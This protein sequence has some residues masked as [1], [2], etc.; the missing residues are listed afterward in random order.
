MLSG[1]AEQCVRLGLLAALQ[2]ASSICIR[3]GLSTIHYSLVTAAGQGLQILQRSR[4]A[5]GAVTFEFKVS[6]AGSGSFSV[7]TDLSRP[8]VWLGSCGI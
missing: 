6:F 5:L 1:N 8:A 2:E 4:G 3:Q 7:P